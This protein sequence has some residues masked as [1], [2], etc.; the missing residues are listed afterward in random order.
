MRPSC[1][2]AVSNVVPGARIGGRYHGDEEKALPRTSKPCV[3]MQAG[4]H[5]AYTSVMAASEEPIAPKVTAPLD[6]GFVAS[7]PDP[8]AHLAAVYRDYPGLRALI[9]R[10]VRDPEI[11]ALL[12]QTMQLPPDRQYDPTASPLAI[13]SRL[14][15][16]SLV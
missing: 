10:R 13:L 9:L 1:M 12:E 4:R 5:G 6:A 11:A 3:P 8:V 7:A 2:L 15:G 16:R 14:A